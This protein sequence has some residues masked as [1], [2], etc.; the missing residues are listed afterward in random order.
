MAKDSFITEPRSET[1]ET[2]Q[3][4]LS[5]FLHVWFAP[6]GCTLLT[7]LPQPVGA[8]VSAWWVLASGTA[9]WHTS[10]QHSFLVPWAKTNADYL[11]S[12]FLLPTLAHWLQKC[13]NANF[14]FLCRRIEIENGQNLGLQ[15]CA[16][17]WHHILIN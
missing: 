4:F 16:H 12:F 1:K 11:I 13:L 17:L 6:S 10:R 9:S 7:L 8:D 5:G 3:D 2:L 14:V 15:I